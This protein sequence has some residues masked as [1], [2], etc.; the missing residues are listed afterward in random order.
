MLGELCSSVQSS[1]N[2][3][4]NATVQVLFFSSFPENKFF[5][6]NTLGEAVIIS[7]FLSLQVTSH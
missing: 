5:E 1:F 6:H 7:L 4:A 2:F 3:M